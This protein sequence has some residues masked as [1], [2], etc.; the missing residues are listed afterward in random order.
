MSAMKRSRKDTLEN[1]PTYLTSIKE[2]IKADMIEK[3]NADELAS[4][5]FTIF[6][7]E[8]VNV[9]T[10]S[11]GILDHIFD[12]NAFDVL[13]H[14]YDTIK[15]IYDFKMNRP[16]DPL[17]SNKQSRNVR[18]KVSVDLTNIYDVANNIQAR[19]NFKG[20]ISK[21]PTGTLKMYETKEH[22]CNILISEFCTQFDPNFIFSFLRDAT[23][24]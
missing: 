21:S 3:F 10:S 24:M 8:N 13:S 7:G 1:N 5:F 22:E 11:T 20:V 16:S 6:T 23:D 9:P 17:S 4:I 2:S 18:R 14:R 15:R 19:L 12:G